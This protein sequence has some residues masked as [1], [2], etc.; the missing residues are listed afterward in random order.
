MSLLRIFPANAARLMTKPSTPLGRY[1]HSSVPGRTG[2]L[3]IKAGMMAEF[4]GWGMRHELTVLFLDGCQ[5]VQAKTKEKNGYTALQLGVSNA[6]AKN[7]TKPLLQ[8]FANAGVHPKRKL[9]EFR[10]N[11]DAI[12]PLGTTIPASHFVPGQL[13][14]V[15]GVSKGKGFQGVMKRHGFGG[16]RASHGVSKAHR[17]LGSTGQCQ[18][19]GKVFKGK[20]MPGRMGSDNVTMQNLQVFKV[21]SARNLVYLKGHV[22]G[23]A[24]GFVR[25]VDAVKGPHFPCAEGDVPYPTRLIQ[26]EGGAATGDEEGASVFYA[27]GMAGDGELDPLKPVEN[28]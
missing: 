3:A 5:V 28:M 22:P 19:P 10:V 17:S 24:G 8:H 21:D 11:P 15:S 14:D 18:D 26:E 6:K 4:D 23:N 27:P 13:V 16:G 7:I 1:I 12:L 9:G 25:I 20:K 2:A